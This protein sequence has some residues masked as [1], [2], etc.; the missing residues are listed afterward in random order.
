[1]TQQTGQLDL[2][3]LPSPGSSTSGGDASPAAETVSIL[4]DASFSSIDRHFALLMERLGGRVNP[5]LGLAAALVSRSRG[6][7]NIC[8]HL[9]TLAGTRFPSDPPEPA[10][11]I[12][13]PSL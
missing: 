7:G 12:Q 8:L 5:L 10:G 2:F 4:E 9:E 3:A 11:S 1:M 6:A 13:L